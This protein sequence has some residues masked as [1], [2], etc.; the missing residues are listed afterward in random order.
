MQDP[1]I[2]LMAFL[3]SGWSLT[4]DL[5]KANIRFSTGWYNRRFEAPQVSVTLLWERDVV[6]G[7]GYTKHGVEAFY[8]INVWVKI[9]KSGTGKGPGLAKKWR[10]EMK[11][12]VKALLK[13]QLEGYTD[14]KVVVLDQIARPFDELDGAPPLLRFSIPVHVEYEI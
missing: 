12:H 10:H 1:A 11:E 6:L 8:E 14:L 3:K 4:G 5:A 7:L 13:A 2:T 9:L